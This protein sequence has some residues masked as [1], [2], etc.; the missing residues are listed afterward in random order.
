MDFDTKY[1]NY[2]MAEDH[3][4]KCIA[5]TPEYTPVYLN[6]SITLSTLGKYDDQ[7]A[8]L[9]KAL[10]VPGI[11]K[12]TINNELGIMYELLGQF[13]AAMDHYKLA[14]RHS[15]VDANIELYM[16]SMERCKKKKNIL[17]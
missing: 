14:I 4:R 3:Y 1:R 7:K 17:G 16:S 6:L 9:M 13:D 15:L 5:Y 2:Q 12:A 10:E 8:I 11:D